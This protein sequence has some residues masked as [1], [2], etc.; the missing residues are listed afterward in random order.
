MKRLVVLCAVFALLAASLFAGGTQEGKTQA[1]PA[2]TGPKVLNFPA[3][4]LGGTYYDWMKTVYNR[5]GQPELVQISL[6]SYDNNYAVHN[7]AADSMSVSDDGLTWTIKL[8][9]NLQW[10]D[11]S[12]LTADDFVF[13]LQRAALEGYDFGW[14]WSWAA[15]IK[16]WDAVQKKDVPVDQLGVKAID[17]Y[18]IQ[19]QTTSPKPYFPGIVT[20]WYAVPKKQVQKYGD[21]YATKVD[22]MLC[23]GPFMLTEWVKDN[24]IVMVK[25]PYYHGPWVP[26]VDQINMYPTLS[27]AQ[28][29]FPAYLAGDIDMTNVDVGQLAVARDKFPT[30]IKKN[31]TFQIFYISYDYSTPPFNDVNV[32]KAFFYSINRDELT[33]TVLK[34]LAIPAHTLVAPGFPGY[35]EAIAK[36]SVFDPVKAADYLAKA[37][38]PGGKGFP[39]VTFLWREEGGITQVTKPMSEYLQAQWKKILG[40]DIT[41]DSAD[42]KT[43]MD[44]LLH[45]KYKMFLSPYAFDYVDASNF[46]DLFVTPGSR[47][48]WTNADYNAVVQKADAT[49]KWEDRAPLYQQAEQIMV[50]Q[51]AIVD[52]IHPLQYNLVKPYV[53]GPGVEP[54]QYGFYPMLSVYTWTHLTTEK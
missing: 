22:T 49:F 20:V 15:G 1:K 39:N 19:V 3:A 29:G 14:Y 46:Y 25:N 6:T 43:W 28:Q 52:L 4:S 38:Y 2:A 42:V 26:M 13:A 23:S 41:I 36:Q 45:L 35:S 12:P 18:T 54:N 33:N 34:D 40:V 8:L 7:I 17:D 16:N 27:E 44:D 11:G 10:S 24:K 31:A 51:A 47:H 50:D 9:K 32:R 30:E 48:N 21:E 37:G 53:K 5:T